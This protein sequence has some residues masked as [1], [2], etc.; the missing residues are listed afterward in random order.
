VFAVAVVLIDANDDPLS[1]VFLVLAAV[2]WT[3]L[4]SALAD[5]IGEPPVWFNLLFLSAGI[6]LNAALLLLLGRWLR[7]VRA[8]G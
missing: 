2:P 1:A 8:H 4:L 3:F 6:L 5:W 7:R